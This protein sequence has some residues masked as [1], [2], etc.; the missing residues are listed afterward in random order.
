MCTTVTFPSMLKFTVIFKVQHLMLYTI[1]VWE[2]GKLN[3]VG[4]IVKLGVW[5]S[6]L[7]V[8]RTRHANMSNR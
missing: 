7:A 1:V 3:E 4:V 8:K 2:D 5:W 6:C